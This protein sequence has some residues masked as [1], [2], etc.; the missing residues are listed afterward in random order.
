[1]SIEQQKNGVSEEI[2]L[3]YYNQVLFSQAIITEHERSKMALL[4]AARKPP[5]KMAERER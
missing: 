1:M 2:W 5:K 4:I 3:N